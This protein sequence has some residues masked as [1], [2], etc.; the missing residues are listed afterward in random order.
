LESADFEAHP[1]EFG[2][3]GT[4]GGSLPLRKED[5]RSLKLLWHAGR[6]AIRS[7]RHFRCQ[8]DLASRVHPPGETVT[9]EAFEDSWLHIG[10][11]GNGIAT[12]KHLVNYFT[13]PDLNTSDRRRVLDRNLR[14]GLVLEVTVGGDRDRWFTTPEALEGLDT[15]PEPEG[16]TLLCPF[17]SFL[18]QRQRAED[19]LDFRYRIEI[20]VPAAMRQFG[21]YVLPILHQGRLVGRLDPK[22][23]RER[24]ELQIRSLFFED[25]VKPDRKLVRGLRETLHDLAEFVGATRLELP[26]SWSRLA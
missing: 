13:T 3:D 24:D 9:K 16:T 21:Y 7:R 10:L 12:E 22:L 6:V 26:A 17:D 15:I 23:H 5:S 1:G 2:P 14:A 20:Y 19:L 25:G 4:P 18:W 8:Y 11:S